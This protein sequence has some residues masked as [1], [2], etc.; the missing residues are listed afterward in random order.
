M[1]AMDEDAPVV[2]TTSQSTL[3]ATMHR[4]A[5]LIAAEVADVDMGLDHH[6]RGQTAQISEDEDELEVGAE[7]EEGIH[8]GVDYENIW[9]G[10]VCGLPV[11]EH[12]RIAQECVPGRAPFSGVK[13][14]NAMLRDMARHKGSMLKNRLSHLAE[15]EYNLDTDVVVQYG[16][17]PEVAMTESFGG[18]RMDESE[19]GVIRK[20]EVGNAKRHGR[21]VVGP[22]EH[23]L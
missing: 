10:A 23:S 6:V 11:A 12:T 5:P 22:V 9:A 20:R 16:Q 1:V 7:D 13:G 2:A 21:K 18:D 8:D 19:A 14:K 15:G 17:R 4:E 3:M